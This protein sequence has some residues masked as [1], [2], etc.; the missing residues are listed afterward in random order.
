MAK[1]KLAKIQADAERLV[2]KF[3]QCTVAMA[4]AVVARMQARG[5]DVTVLN[6]MHW[7]DGGRTYHTFQRAACRVLGHKTLPRDEWFGE[8]ISL[9]DPLLRRLRVKAG[10]R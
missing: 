10:A 8:E 7:L 4:V 6:F 3:G 1:Q 2:P 9:L 5:Y